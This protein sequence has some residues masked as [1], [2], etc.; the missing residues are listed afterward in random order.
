MTAKIV[1]FMNQKGGVGKTTTTVNIGAI[2]AVEHGKRVLLVDLDPQGNMSD[3]LGLDPVRLEGASLYEVLIDR[4]DPRLAIRRMHDVEVIPVDFHLAGVEVELARDEDRDRRLKEALEK[5]REQ[6]DYILLDCPP[7]LALLTVMGLAAAD[8]VLVPME[9]EYLALRGI[10]QLIETVRLVEES[11]NPGLAVDGVIFCRYDGRTTLARD[12][13]TEVEKHLPG[14]VFSTAI[15]RNIRLAEAPS[16]GLSII[17]YDPRCA[18]AE[19]YRLTVREFLNRFE[20]AAA[21][22]EVEVEVERTP[23]DIMA[24]TPILPEGGDGR[25]SWQRQP[26]WK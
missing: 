12:V 17:H 15:R 21:E 5:V 9:A 25:G 6:Y 22:S 18:G 24:E 2:L 11:M 4:L 10:G 14:K 8:L 20:L 7:S 23:R 13:K 26:K 16:R 1:A 19:D 3:H